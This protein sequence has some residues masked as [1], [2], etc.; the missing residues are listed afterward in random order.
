[1]RRIPFFM[2]LALLLVGV[3]VTVAQQT[4]APSLQVVDQ[5][6]AANEVGQNSPIVVYFD[7]P[8][9]CASAQAA[10]QIDPQVAGD[11]TCSDADASVTFTPA[12]GYQSGTTYTVSFADSLR[13]ADGS[14]LAAPFSMTVSTSGVLEVAQV[15]PADGSTGVETDSVITVIFNRP[16]V[17]LVIAE[18][19]AKLPQPLTFAPAVQGKGEWI[20]TSIY[21]FHP[22]PALQ[23]G[24]Q[25]A[26]G[27]S[28]DLTAVDGSTLAQPFT[29][30]FST[31]APA[32]SEVVPKDTTMD[33]RLGATLQARFNQPMDQ[34]SVESSFSLHPLDSQQKVSGTFEWA[35][36]GSGFRFT[37]DA[38]L[39]IDTHYVAEFTTPPLPEGGGSPLQGQQRW[40]FSTVSLPAVI[41]TK[42]L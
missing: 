41:N 19:A 37:P 2:L 14:S 10:F 4:P 20:N 11:V 30:S 38:N 27:V 32:L 40:D 21:Q 26:V 17:P 25:Y 13:G 7:R 36:D 22:D 6:P 18:D 12:E 33:V 42:P 9:D 16:V 35:D 29:W 34:A 31:A 39:Q 28:S 5:A 8:V 1:M 3:S 23:G 15:L 24:T